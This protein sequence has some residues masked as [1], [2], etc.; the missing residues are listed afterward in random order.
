[1][2][3]EQ[4][5]RQR[6]EVLTARLAEELE[7]E[8]GVT[9]DPAHVADVVRSKVDQLADAPV[10]D[11]VTLLAEHKALEDLRAEGLHRR[12]PDDPHLPLRD[13]SEPANSVGV[14]TVK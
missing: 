14:P 1:M 8:N 11:F 12:L 7:D 9:P 10:Q 4:A 6:T 5:E 2:A 3:H 13:D